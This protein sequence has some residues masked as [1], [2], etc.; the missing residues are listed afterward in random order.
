[1]CPLTLSPTGEVLLPASFFPD[2][3]QTS[4]TPVWR[5]I[6]PPVSAV[7]LLFSVVPLWNRIPGSR[8]VFATGEFGHVCFLFF[9]TR[10]NFLFLSGPPVQERGAP[11][12]FGTFFPF[13]LFSGPCG[14]F[15]FC[16]PGKDMSPLRC[17]GF[18]RD[19][20]R[21]FFCFLCS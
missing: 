3:R 12:I 5:G 19:T 15:P 2:V 10:T 20:R 6:L 11:P 4:V 8:R 18:L 9:P 21:C 14:V 7:P 17:A 13:F 1:L 16:C